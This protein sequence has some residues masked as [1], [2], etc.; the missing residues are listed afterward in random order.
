[1]V[2]PHQVGDLVRC[3][4]RV[5][6][7]E[8]KMSA[9]VLICNLSQP[10]TLAPRLLIPRNDAHDTNESSLTPPAPQYT[11]NPPPFDFG[12]HKSSVNLQKI[13]EQNA[14]LKKENEILKKRL[15]VFKH[16]I[17]CYKKKKRSKNDNMK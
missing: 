6:G 16:I 13:K 10:I 1:M 2:A 5:P 17:Q 8:A 7:C 4:V 14:N 3:F 11:N 12:T 9:K 15:S